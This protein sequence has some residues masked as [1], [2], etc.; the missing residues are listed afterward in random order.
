LE[1]VKYVGFA[2]SFLR[3]REVVF[4]EDEGQ[5]M[6]VVVGDS[7][8]G[9]LL[10]QRIFICADTLD[11]RCSYPEHLCGFVVIG[12]LSYCVLEFES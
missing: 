7:G 1:A 10:K 8:C 9:F 11:G 5:Q 3:F 2:D 12:D 4:P 6:F